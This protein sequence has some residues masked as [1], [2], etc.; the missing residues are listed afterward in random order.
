MNIFRSLV[1]ILIVLGFNILNAQKNAKKQMSLAASSI[2]LKNY[3]AAIEYLEV[4]IK[5]ANKENKNRFIYLKGIVHHVKNDTTMARKTYK[6]ISSNSW[7]NS[8]KLA[9]AMLTVLNREPENAIAVEQRIE[10]HKKFEKKLDSLGSIKEEIPLTKHKDS[11]ADFAVIESIPFMDSCAS[12]KSNQ[13]RKACFNKE[14]SNLLSKNFD[15]G[16]ARDLGLYGKISLRCQ[17]TI[18]KKGNVT[19]VRVR[20]SHPILRLE[21]KRV[22][23]LLPK[24]NPGMQKGKPVKVVYSLP[25]KFVVTN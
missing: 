22:I 25:I 14:I 16:L 1:I 18:D 13:A 8:F 10:D 2:E 9:Q 12:S 19:A 23:N 21:A 24:M 15:T 3:D 4:A 11:V 17:F 6:S 5:K 20:G 7:D